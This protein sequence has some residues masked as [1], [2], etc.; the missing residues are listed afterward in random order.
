M[1]V[2]W[3][4]KIQHE[5]EI[6][7]NPNVNRAFRYG[8]GFFETIRIV[9]KH[10]PLFPFHWK[11]IEDAAKA[12]EFE[13]PFQQ[14][15]LKDYIQELCAATNNTQAVIRLN[16]FSEG[17]GNYMVKKNSSIQFGMTIRTYQANPEKKFF[18][19]GI[20][21][22]TLFSKNKHAQF[23][24][25]NAMP[26]IQM[27]KECQSKNWDTGI[28]LNEKEEAVDACWHSFATIKDDMICFPRENAGGVASCASAALKNL[29]NTCGVKFQI[30]E[31]DLNHLN[32]SNEI[33]FLNAID[34]IVP[35]IQWHEKTLSTKQG[36]IIARDFQSFYYF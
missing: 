21:E 24:T 10:A 9:N 31:I 32:N 29:L 26:Y 15:Q 6:A 2:I 36:E 8:E 25:M 19:S 12:F 23:K 35:L 7:L 20:L 3:N 18:K 11:R 16:V 14:Q 17:D 28:A 1:Q 30:G 27:A 4:G 5:N 13:I 33:F 34:G 22:H